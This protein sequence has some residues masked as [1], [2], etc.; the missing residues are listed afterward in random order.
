[1][2]S[3]R[4]LDFSTLL[5]IQ[6]RAECDKS[7]EHGTE[8]MYTGRA[9]TEN[10]LS[11]YMNREI[12]PETTENNAKDI[13]QCN[14]KLYLQRDEC[15]HLSLFIPCI[16]FRWMNNIYW[17]RLSLKCSAWKG[18]INV[19]SKKFRNKFKVLKKICVKI[20]F[21]KQAQNLCIAA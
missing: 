7:I 11:G 13:C 9:D 12:Q 10:L 2:A 14:F 20:F 4:K 3:S 19:A 8:I 21:L 17:T 6:D 18:F 1:M 16:S 5:R 15:T